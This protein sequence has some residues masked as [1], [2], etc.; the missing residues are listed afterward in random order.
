MRSR[1]RTFSEH[2]RTKSSALA[3]RRLS[4]VLVTAAL[5][6]GAA[7]VGTPFSLADAPAKPNSG[8]SDKP[9]PAE[10]T[11]PTP[12]RPFIESITQVSD[13]KLRVFVSSP[14]M[15]RTVEVQV[16]LPRNTS[17]PRPVVYMLDGR[18]AKSESN[19]WTVL[20]GAAEFFEDKDVTVVLTVG[21]P[22]SYYTD[23][24]RED[25]VL[26]LNRWETFLTD[27]LPP[28]IN[29][30][31]DGNGRNAVMGVS[32]GAEGALMLA[33]RQPEL[34]AAVAGHS[35]CY[36][37]GSDTG[38]AQA[39]AVVATYNGK[40]DNMFGT[41]DDPQWRAHDVLSQAEALRGKAIYL[42]AGSGMPGK[43]DVPGNPE[44]I[45]AIGFGGPLEAGAFTCTRSLAE[46]LAA[47]RIPATVNLRSTGTHSWPYWVDEL[48]ASWPA[49]SA[50]LS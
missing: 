6:A 8:S 25:P 50:G 1:R 22:A 29:A 21:G 13:R 4:G 45:S 17:Q 16:L 15:H 3:L 24:Y 41:E 9:D 33:V 2:I 7:A 27:E 37:M 14:A 28:L 34:Y 35:G 42:S 5:L 40:A 32:M 47:L 19:N 18:S 43:Y 36:E 31:F 46:R 20:G 39:R 44:V 12:D 49:V 23:W 38:Q 10:P 11:S 48:A 26:G 30:R